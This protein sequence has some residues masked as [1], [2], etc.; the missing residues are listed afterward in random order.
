MTAGARLSLRLTGPLLIAVG[1]ASPLCAAP[2]IKSISLRGLQAGATTKL[3]I[4]G[5]DLGENAAVVLPIPIAKQETAAPGNPHRVTIAVTLDADVPPGIY[6][7]RVANA[8]GISNAIAVGVDSLP[9]MPFASEVPRLP[10]ALSGSLTGGQML[11]TSFEAKQG[12]RIVVDLESRRLGGK[13]RPILH[14]YDAQG[15]QVAWSQPLDSIGGDA[16]IDAALPEDGRYTVELHDM[17]YQGSAPGHFRLKI[18]SLHY[19][20]LPFPLAVQRGRATPVSGAISRLPAG[21]AWSVNPQG[22]AAI[23]PLPWSQIPGLTGTRPSVRVSAHP[24]VVEQRDASA[25]QTIAQ[26]RV[27]IS[28]RIASEGE[29]D[30]YQIPV[31]PGTKLAIRVLADRLGSPLDGVLSVRNAKGGQLARSDDT[32]GSGDPELNFNVPANTDAI[33][34]ALSDLHRRGGEAFVYHIEVAPA[35]QPQATVSLAAD[36]ILVPRDG[37]E[38]FEVQ[39]KR[40]GYRGP[41][42]LH[43]RSLPE[44]IEARGATIPAG[45]ARALVT[46]S[47]HAETRGHVLSVVTGEAAEGKQTL[48]VAVEGGSVLPGQPWLKNQL[49]IA[50][51][52]S[53]RLKLEWKN[54]PQTPLPVGRK[55]PLAI[56]L[57]R[58]ENTA[59]N[60]RLS[61]VTS[62]VVPQKKVKKNNKD[63]MVDDLQRALRLEKAPT[64]KEEASEAALTLLVP[65]DLPHLEYDVAVR[66]ELL[67]ADGKKV[68]ARATTPAR[69]LK[70]Q[71]PSPAEPRR[72]FEDEPALPGQ[73]SEGKGDVALVADE[74]F[75]GKNSLRVTPDRRA[76]AKLGELALPIRRFPGPGEYRYLRF[77]WKKKGGQSIALALGHD[78]KLGQQG[79]KGPAY[80][81]LAAGGKPPAG[82][83]QVDKKPPGDWVVVTR[84]LVADFGEFTL[85]GLGLEAADGEAAWFDHIYLGRSRND[86]DLVAPDGEKK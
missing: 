75:A 73:L 39:A 84:D 63:V 7:L 59:G 25:A 15:V 13:L 55:I 42:K 67:A 44:G 65:A 35:G 79:G 57:S 86:F 16:R 49:A 68:V 31:E 28:G 78:G 83:V 66:A 81:Y 54:P 40:Q 70:A 11:E 5:S 24:E 61:L 62:Q 26:P 22:A 21:A 19:A 14:L 29:E 43:F 30:V 20:D 58:A 82:S 64:L 10:V 45:A 56:A 53:S 36:R 47:A 33:Q 23:V 12:D 3:T 8:R 72:L 52:T 48:A 76:A 2:Q 34:L 60:V 50:A 77:A 46:F 6:P 51:T 71:P 9:Q 4:D 32:A 69:R 1:L 74:K 41:V 38:L 27:G 80:R 17:L 85:T 37:H 18:G